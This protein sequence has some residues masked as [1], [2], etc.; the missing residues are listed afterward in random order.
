M[1]VGGVRRERVDVLNRVFGRTRRS[2]CVNARFIRIAD[3]DHRFGHHL[4]EVFYL[5]ENEGIRH[6]T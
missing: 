3:P 1:D 2:A 5:V 6:R 4:E